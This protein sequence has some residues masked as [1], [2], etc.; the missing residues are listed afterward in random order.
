MKKVLSLILALAMMLSMVTVA[1]ADEP[2]AQTA[3]EVDVEYINANT[4]TIVI[5]L[6]SQVAEADLAAAITLTKNGVPVEGDI[7]VLYEGTTATPPHTAQAFLDD[8][9]GKYSS[10]RALTASK[11]HLYS[12][13]PAA[14]LDFGAEY[15]LDIASSVLGYRYVATIVVTE[16]YTEDFSYTSIDE[17]PWY[18]GSTKQHSLVDGKMTINANKSVYT[19]TNSTNGNYKKTFANTTYSPSTFKNMPT[20]SKLNF[21]AELAYSNVASSNHRTAFGFGTVY[22]SETFNTSGSGMPNLTAFSVGG[23]ATGNGG[24]KFHGFLMGRN[25]KT[26]GDPLY[27]NYPEAGISTYMSYGASIV[28][29]ASQ[30]RASS[31]LNSAGTFVDGTTTAF[32]AGETEKVYMY[33][34]QVSNKVIYGGAGDYYN[35]SFEATGVVTNGAPLIYNGSDAKVTVDNLIASYATITEEEFRDIVFEGPTLWNA[36]SD[37]MT[38]DFD[39]ELDADELK[40]NLVIEDEDGEIVD[41]TKVTKLTDVTP[42]TKATGKHSYRIDLSKR[43]VDDAV[44]TLTMLAGRYTDATGNGAVLA[45]DYVKAFSVDLVIVEDFSTYD[46][47][48]VATSAA[49]GNAW[50]FPVASNK[51]GSI[52]IK[53]EAEKPETFYA[54]YS[55]DAKS[56]AVPNNPDFN[57]ANYN[58]H[59]Q[60]YFASDA[61]KNLTD[62][63]TELDLK[64]VSSADGSYDFALFQSGHRT[65]QTNLAYN[66]NQNKMTIERTAAGVAYL[67][68]YA[69]STLTSADASGTN[70]LATAAHQSVSSDA[71]ALATAIPQIGGG[72]VRIALSIKGQDHK[73][74]VGDVVSHAITTGATTP[75]G[76]G[77]PVFGIAQTY[78]SNAVTFAVDNLILSKATEVEIDPLTFGNLVVMDATS[79]D[80]IA[81][82]SLE[83]VTAI[84]ASVTVE[85]I[86]V[87]VSAEAVLAVYKAATGEMTNVVTNATKA[88]EATT[89]FKFENVELR[90]GDTICVY[91][92][93]SFEELVPY[94]VPYNFPAAE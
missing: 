66:K 89:E 72:Y 1:F 17:C 43:F 25:E 37:S 32:T 30:V 11:N 86:G 27:T 90:G 47:N 23:K 8:G 52:T 75:T 14:G 83:G 91:I 5:E 55:T 34:D 3:T 39:V 24:E 60:N 13:T 50:A 46:L 36:A 77:L 41:I 59:G 68:P 84:D 92:W 33:L 57:F 78:T 70:Y 76:N 53:G 71:P 63:T 15:V 40:D 79:K 16:I 93:N 10:L 31:A 22:T 45:R 51:G 19:R 81:D 54:E 20:Q 94:V 62:Y 18:S 58:G 28:S 48:S 74:E 42:E 4:S 67:K 87:S 85:N 80:V 35:Y 49:S 9:K 61:R 7:T 38:L 12:I 21:E 56:Y 88:I 26:D 82:N 73:W 2:V 6:D 69:A 65:N 29:T 64:V 44:Y